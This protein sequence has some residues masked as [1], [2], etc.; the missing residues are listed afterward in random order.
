MTEVPVSI[1]GEKRRNLNE[2]FPKKKKK[3]N[4]NLPLEQVYELV[5]VLCGR[6]NPHF[7][8]VIFT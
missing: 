1:S 5:I 3:N 6:K 8:E 7:L 4:D 2:G